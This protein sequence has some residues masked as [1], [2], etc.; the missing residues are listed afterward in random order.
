MHDAGTIEQIQRWRR[1][2]KWLKSEIKDRS[3]EILAEVRSAEKVLNGPCAYYVNANGAFALEDVE[4]DVLRRAFQRTTE[5]EVLV[6]WLASWEG[7]SRLY[8]AT[9]PKEG[10]SGE[11][12]PNQ[13]GPARLL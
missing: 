4:E 3:R 2:G 7:G 6:L 12:S 11:E 13:R 9:V 1:Q 5:D 8:S 10:S